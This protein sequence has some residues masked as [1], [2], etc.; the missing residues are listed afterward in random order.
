[1]AV[2]NTNRSN[3]ITLIYQQRHTSSFRLKD[4]HIIPQETLRGRAWTRIKSEFPMS[5]FGYQAEVCVVICV[6]EG[7]FVVEFGRVDDFGPV[8][9]VGDTMHVN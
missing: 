7:V 3:I 1:M 9:G 6:H 8:V 2:I 4:T 5:E